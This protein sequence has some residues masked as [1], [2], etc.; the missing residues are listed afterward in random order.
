MFNIFTVAWSFVSNV[1]GGWVKGVFETKQE[2]FRVWQEGIIGLFLALR[3]A[4]IQDVA[5]AQLM[6][7]IWIND[8]N[9]EHFL[10]RSWRPMIG[11]SFAALL[12]AIMCGFA[13]PILTM[14]TI[15]PMLEKLMEMLTFLIGGGMGLRTIDK[16]TGAV[17]KT[18]IANAIMDKI[19]D[20]AKE[21]L[22]LDINKKRNED[23]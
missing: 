17:S 19:G 4:G 3:Q 9:S 22:D 18:K 7:Q 21:D 10:V 23:E 2:K 1:L 12:L 20:S 11:L 5:I 6:S 13:P 8:S 14:N 16:I 15:P